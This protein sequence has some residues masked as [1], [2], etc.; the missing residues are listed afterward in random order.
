MGALASH[1]V[2]DADFVA[3]IGV[4]WQRRPLAPEPG[5]AALLAQ[6][7][8]D[9]GGKAT[10]VQ[11]VGM[12]VVDECVAH[13]YHSMDLV[14]LHPDTPGLD[15]ALERFDKPHTHA[16]DEV[17]YI[18]EGEGLF[19]FFDAGGE[20]R[21]LRVQPGDYLRIPAGVEHRFTLTATRRIKALRLF[22]DT[23]GWVAQYTQRPAAAMEVPA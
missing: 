18:L 19:G 13:G 8:L 3:A 21:V 20:E 14:V 10:V 2:S 17:R 4:Q 15:E 7:Q 23:A 12:L 5:L 1:R 6:A 16:D 11:A 9:D 22:A